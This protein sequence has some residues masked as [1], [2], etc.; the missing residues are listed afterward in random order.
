MTSIHSIYIRT[1]NTWLMLS[2]LL[3]QF[4]LVYGSFR[5]TNMYSTLDFYPGP[6][7]KETYTVH[8]GLYCRAAYIAKRLLFLLN[9]ISRLL[10]YL[11]FTL[12]T[13]S[14]KEQ[15]IEKTTFLLYMCTTFLRLL[16]I[17]LQSGLYYKKIF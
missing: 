8:C 2:A 1:I 14:K 10:F 6:A 12:R 16:Q 9:M 5:Q 17:V 3:N 13:P 4:K 11:S 15:K 7:W